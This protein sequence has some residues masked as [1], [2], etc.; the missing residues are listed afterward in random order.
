MAQ[1]LESPQ[2]PHNGRISY[3]SMPASMHRLSLCIPY[4]GQVLKSFTTRVWLVRKFQPG[5]SDPQGMYRNVETEQSSLTLQTV[6]KWD[7]SMSHEE[8]D[9]LEASPASDWRFTSFRG[10]GICSPGLGTF[11]SSRQNTV[12]FCH[13]LVR[14]PRQYTV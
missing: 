8:E 5:I 4:R 9:E 12:W 7:L 2:V 1:G 11:R 6:D 14:N 13:G 10:V 3:L